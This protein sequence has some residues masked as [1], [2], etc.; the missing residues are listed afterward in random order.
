MPPDLMWLSPQSR[1]LRDPVESKL[2]GIWNEAESPLGPCRG[3]L[4]RFPGP[5]RWETGV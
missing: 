4:S 2:Q 3:S 5:G 1:I